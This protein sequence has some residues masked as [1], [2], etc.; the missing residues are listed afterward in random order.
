MANILMIDDGALVTS[1]L[2]ELL[3]REDHAVELANDESE[4][5][6]LYNEHLHDLIVG[7]LR[8]PEG[9]EMVG[10]LLRRMPNAR[11]LAI[12]SGEVLQSDSILTKA[13]A[14][15]NIRVLRKPFSIDTFLKTVNGQINDD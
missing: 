14:F 15:G 7:D 11:I 3:R 13:N 5:L 6:E 4:A 1:W 12:V 9:L 8:M 10:E 2:S